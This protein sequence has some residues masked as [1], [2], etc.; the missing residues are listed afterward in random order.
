MVQPTILHGNPEVSSSQNEPDFSLVLGGPLYQLYLGTRLARPNLELVVRRMLAASLICWLPLL[1]L[2]AVAGH[3]I[4]GVPVPFLRD[5]GVHIRFLLALPLLIASEVLVHERLQN[6]VPQFLN[7]GIIASEDRPH[8]EKLVTSAMSLRNSVFMEIILIVLTLTMGHWL[9][10]HNFN[11][12]L[13]SWYQ[14]YAPTG[15]RLTAGGWYYSFVSLSIFRFILFR[16]YF[17]LF[18]WYRFLWQVKAMPLHFNLY[19]PDRAGGL[20]F[21]SASINAFAPVFVAQTAVVAGNI[22]T[23]IRYSGARLP[24]FLTEIAGALTFSVFALIFPLGFFGL[25]LERAARTAKRE[26]GLLASNYVNAF[27]RKWIEEPAR[28]GEPLLGT[29]DIQSLADLANSFE[30]ASRIRILPISKEALIRLV[31]LIAF[32]FLPL[33]F[34]MFPL[35]EVIRR[36]FKLMF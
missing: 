27:R 36:V 23:Q 10:R 15:S 16:W 19:H 33:I 26:F 9:W 5:P 20:G 12:N 17:R 4:D 29:S 18:I 7:R 35:S 3:L 13:S 14:D 11:L 32:P 25:P 1:V 22:F 2:A 34:T 24:N 21:L 8:F 31:V 28:A 6:I 30:V